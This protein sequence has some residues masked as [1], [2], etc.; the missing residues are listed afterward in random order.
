[1][2]AERLAVPSGARPPT[3]PLGLASARG[4]TLIEL[5]AVIA[6]VGV[7]ATLICLLV[8]RVEERNR[9]SRARA[10][11]EQMQNAI[12]DY[13]AQQGTFPQSLAERDFT[14]RLPRG[15]DFDASGVPVDPWKQLYVY[16]T[17]NELYA[18]SS[19]GPDGL[20]SNDDDIVAGR[21]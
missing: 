11:I 15:F 1:M 17:T 3:A 5:L 2:G 7:L 8:R 4:F 19:A 6:I 10:Q 9:C 21:F 18:L 16:S 12:Q 14:N 13:R 20:Q